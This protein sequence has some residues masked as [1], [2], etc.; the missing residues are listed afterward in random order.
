[1]NRARFRIGPEALLALGLLLLLLV[2]TGAAAEAPPRPLSPEQAIM[3]SLEQAKAGEL[4]PAEAVSGLFLERGMTTAAHALL[5]RAYRLAGDHARAS[6]HY[7]LALASAPSG[8]LHAELASMLLD[9][10]DYE[11]AQYHL[12]RALELGPPPAVLG[13]TRALLDA[14][15][16]REGPYGA[17]RAGVSVSS[18]V[19][20]GSPEDT[21]EIGGL[22]FELSKDARAKSGMGPLLDAEA[23]WRWRLTPGLS[24]FGQG[25][26]W[27]V[28]YL[29]RKEDR[30]IPSARLGLEYRHGLFLWRP[31]TQIFYERYAGEGIRRGI[32]FDNL[33]S[34]PPLGRTRFEFRLAPGWIDGLNGQDSYARYRAEASA[35]T[36]VHPRLRLRFDLGTIYEDHD[37]AYASNWLHATAASLDWLLP[38]ASILRLQ[39]GYG[40]NR[41]NAEDPVFGEER[42]EHVLTA[43]A[44]V[45]LTNWSYA[46][47]APEVGAVRKVVRSNVDFYDRSGT[48]FVFAL[49]KSF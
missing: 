5:A 46:G 20:N 19:N 25:N 43:G 7:R 16:G 31:S 29:D 18:N 33:V 9:D 38:N 35:I 39:L 12:E 1:M 23:G 4:G 26:L 34:P 48:D 28:S 6:E 32:E 49:T 36:G 41:Y 3:L 2:R 11:A 21:V 47:W 14:L 45:V 17:V 8:L 44:T 22:T 27:A 10:G 24:A 37:E 13:R 40:L 15:R 30:A 42:E